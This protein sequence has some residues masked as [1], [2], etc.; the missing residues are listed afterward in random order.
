MSVL[1][2]TVT[3]CVTK[4]Y[5]LLLLD[6]S[7]DPPPLLANVL[8]R[9][10]TEEGQFVLSFMTLFI[11]LFIYLFIF[12]FFFSVQQFTISFFFIIIIIMLEFSSLSLC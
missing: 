3:R 1:E 9:T 5:P 10:I 8:T 7:G 4:G 6:L 12:F 11:Y 2:D